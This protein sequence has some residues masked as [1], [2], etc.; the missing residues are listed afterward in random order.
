VF[1]F[2]TIPVIDNDNSATYKIWKL[3]SPI[4]ADP[5]EKVVNHAD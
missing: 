4:S 3:I 5:R 1:T 2:G